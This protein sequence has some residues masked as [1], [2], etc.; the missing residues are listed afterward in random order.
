[1]NVGAVPEDARIAKAYLYWSAWWTTDGADRDVTLTVTRPGAGG[2]VP[3]TAGRWYVIED[4]GVDNTYEYSCFADVTD[5]VKNI[6]A[7]VADTTFTVSGVDATSA[8]ACSS[9][10][11]NQ[12]SYAGWSMIIIYSSEQKEPRH[13]YLYDGLAFLWNAYAEFTITG[14]EAPEGDNEAKLTIFAGEGD[15]HI[16]ADSLQFKGQGDAQYQDL[17]DVSNTKY[18]FNSMSDTGG[19]TASQMPG[20][21]SGQIS[22]VDIDTY[23]STRPSG[24][25]PLSDIV[26][27]GDTTAT[28]KAR[29]TGDGFMLIYLIFSVRST[30]APTDAGPQ[31][32]NMIYRIE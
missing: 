12:S 32:D 19:F 13:I 11:A 18:V 16:S 15:S 24:G 10:L 5:A 22:G 21:S 23:S 7:E 6:T 31:V 26:Q 4:T 17:Y 28:I 8:T 9:N 25:T 3:V 20:Q 2:T 1:V 14:F 27:P 29:S 30:N